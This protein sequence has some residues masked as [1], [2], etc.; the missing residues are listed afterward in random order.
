MVYVSS[1]EPNARVPKIGSRWVWEID[2][3]HA[4]E[5]IEVTKVIWD[6]E[7]WWVQTK[8]LLG[9]GRCGLPSLDPA[10]PLN[11][12]SRFWEA[13]EPVGNTSA[14]LSERGN[15]TATVET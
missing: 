6:G 13:A 2:K 3:P 11:D 15:P 4:R 12:L 9:H 8:S 14:K 10:D 5:L 7:E 1:Y